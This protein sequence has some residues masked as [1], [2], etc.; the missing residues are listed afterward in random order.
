MF[1]LNKFTPSNM[2][3]G[4][5]GKLPISEVIRSTALMFR[6]KIVNCIINRK[7]IWIMY[8]LARKMYV[9][10]D[11]YVK[12]VKFRLLFS[13]SKHVKNIFL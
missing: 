5:S 9:N 1:R 12:M 6:F 7:L 3:F 11:L 10:R 4:E 13:E 2:V 8:Q